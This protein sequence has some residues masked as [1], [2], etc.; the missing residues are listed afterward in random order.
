[1]VDLKVADVRCNSSENCKE[2]VLLLPAAL[3]PQMLSC[4]VEETFVDSRENTERF[5]VGAANSLRKQL[6]SEQFYGGIVRLIRHAGHEYQEK[7]DKGVLASLKSTLQS[8]KFHGKRKIVTHLLHN[9]SVI[10]GSEKEVPYF[11]EK[12]FQSGQEIW[13]IYVDAVEDTEETMSA[14]A[15]T[16]SK[17]IKDACKGLLR[18]TA[19][20]I[21]QM[22]HSR[23]GKICSLL[24]SMKIRQD[25]SYDAGKGDVFP[26]PG[27]FIPIADHHL[28]NPNF[29]SLK[30]R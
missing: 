2:L 29:K 10:P 9:G 17:V 14:V 3:Q 28:L 11:L 27:S 24:D 25:D 8:I 26:T 30:T 12:V 16:L 15:F 4:A 19:M 22:L 20:Y 21:P 6:H 5:D 13:Y 1:M 7:V 18:D 23:P